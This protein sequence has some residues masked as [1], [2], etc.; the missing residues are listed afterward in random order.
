MKR[1]PATKASARWYR[2][3]LRDLRLN[4]VEAAKLIGVQQW[5]SN[6]WSRGLQA[7]PEPVRRLLELLL[8]HPSLIAEVTSRAGMKPIVFAENR[9]ERID[10]EQP[11]WLQ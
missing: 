2:A 3:A 4:Q 11:W 5:T 8:A 7:V 6:K 1:R 10:T 9:A